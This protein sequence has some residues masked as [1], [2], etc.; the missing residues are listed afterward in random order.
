MAYA[1]NSANSR[2]LTFGGSSSLAFENNQPMTLSGWFFFPTLTN[3]GVYQLF[4]KQLNSGTA[5]GWNMAF[6]YQF[7]LSNGGTN[8]W[9]TFAKRNGSGNEA[10][11][12]AV[13]TFS[14]NTWV[15][16]C[17]SMSN[18]TNATAIAHYGNG[19]QLT[20]FIQT[21]TLTGS[22]LSSVAPQINGRNGANNMNAFNAAEIGVY[23]AT[24]TAAE[25]AS[26]AN[27]MTCDKVRPQSLVFYAPL[28]RDLTDQKGGL[29]ITNNNGA[30][31]A[32]HTRVYA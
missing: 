1:L 28:V 5:A 12:A 18:S 21:N 22:I 13:F 7:N 27:G 10:Q 11:A 17:V 3:G 25:I 4:N 29:T 31:V 16:C 24:L 19:Q 6:L 15:H 9:L 26:L 2:Y 14:S 30:T 32:T 20:S 23:N 8:N